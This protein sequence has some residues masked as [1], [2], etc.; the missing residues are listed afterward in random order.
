MKTTFD[1]TQ[2]TSLPTSMHMKVGSVGGVIKVLTPHKGEVLLDWQ[3]SGM[4]SVH[5][6][7]A[8]AMVVGLRRLETEARESLF[9]EWVSA[10][11]LER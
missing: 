1:P 2:F 6:T 7:T 4:F 3:Y 9:K 8:S 5:E 11:K 10:N